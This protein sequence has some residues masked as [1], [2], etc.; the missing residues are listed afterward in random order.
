MKCVFCAAPMPKS[1]LVCDYCNKRNPL[2]L[3]SLKYTEH[4]ADDSPKLTCSVCETHMSQINVGI[5]EDILIHNCKECDG[6]FVT[7][8]NLQKTIKHHIGV[9]QIV[10]YGMLRFILDNPRHESNN[11]TKYKDCPIC[12]QRMRKLNYASVSGVLVDRCLEHGVWLDSGELQQ[13]FEWKSTFA[14][15]KQ[16]EIQD[17]RV[18]I[19][20]V[21]NKDRKYSRD[22]VHNPFENFLIWVLGAGMV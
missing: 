9:L 1:G 17:G 18:K 4:T 13:L 12:K 3:S 6:V 10:D 16:Q 5:A 15:L 21:H 11:D 19:L 14:S 8:E 7:E 20:K 2:N 22:A